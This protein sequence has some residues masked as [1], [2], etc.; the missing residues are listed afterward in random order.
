[1][2]ELADEM[3][4]K[5]EPDRL[6]ERAREVATHKATEL[7]QHAKEAAVE[8]ATELKTQARETLMHKSMELKERADSPKGWSLLGALVGAGVGSALMRK[9]FTTRAARQDSEFAWERGER[10]RYDGLRAGRDDLRSTGEEAMGTGAGGDGPLTDMKASASDKAHEVKD[11]AHEVKDKALDKA[12]EIRERTAGVV[13]KARERASH[14]RE[15]VPSREAVQHQAADW[16]NRTV[17]EQPLLLAVGGIT[18]GMLASTLLPVTGK[19]RKLIEPAKRRATEGVSQL[20]GQL[21]EKLQEEEQQAPGGPGSSNQ[22][23]SDTSSVSASHVETT[24]VE[25]SGKTL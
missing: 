15:R 17:D 24:R 11:K 23:A 18:L 14:A 19:E 3:A 12:T 6:K 13:H 25:D 2:S 7:K 4:R 5:A 20:G 10:W 9:A 21:Q 16:L 22:T 8:K 1:M